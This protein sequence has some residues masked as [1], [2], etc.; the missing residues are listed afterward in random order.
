MVSGVRAAGGPS[1]SGDL[2]NWRQGDRGAGR[3]G[4]DISCVR[5]EADPQ[6]PLCRVFL[7]L[8]ESGSDVGDKGVPGQSRRQRHQRSPSQSRKRGACRVN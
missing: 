7:A 5:R 2:R 8:Q 4:A 3:A 6:S 1:F